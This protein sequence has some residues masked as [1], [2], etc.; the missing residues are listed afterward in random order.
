MKV[1]LIILLVIIIPILWILFTEITIIIDS[2]NRIYEL[3][4]WSIGKAN[5]IIEGE[6]IKFFVQL[7]FIHKQLTID[8]FDY[9]TTTSKKEKK[10]DKKREVEKKQSKSPFSLNKIKQLMRTFEF[11]KF[12]LNVDLGDSYYNALMFPVISLFKYH[13][14]NVNINFQGN[15]E[16]LLVVKNRLIRLLYTFIFKS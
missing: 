3:K 12:Y 6:N 7:F 5:V 15:Y 2:R 14:I 11:R 9:F 8:V 1:I 16:L 4:I 13:H 10:K